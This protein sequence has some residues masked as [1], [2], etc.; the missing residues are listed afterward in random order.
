MNYFHFLKIYNHNENC[1]QYKTV[2]T[3]E[4]VAN[5]KKYFIY[6]FCSR[7]SPDVMYYGFESL[8]I[9]SLFSLY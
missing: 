3:S 1:H 8:C 5:L 4:A 7:R 6:I 2:V 9:I